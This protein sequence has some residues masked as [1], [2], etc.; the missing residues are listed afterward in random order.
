MRSFFFKERTSEESNFKRYP[1]TIKL[2]N[3]S[4]KSHMA[5]GQ[6]FWAP[7][8]LYW[9]KEK[10]RKRDPAAC[11]PRWGFLFDPGSTPRQILPSAEV[12]TLGTACL[13]RSK[14]TVLD[15]FFTIWPWL[16]KKASDNHRFWMVMVPFF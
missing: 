15:F 5:M 13:I 2:N 3:C 16:K 6:K 10:T 11:D 7:K 12:S 8:N 1:E 9:L 14:E 4:N